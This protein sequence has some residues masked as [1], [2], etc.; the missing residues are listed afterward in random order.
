MALPPSEMTVAGMGE[1]ASTMSAGDA[2]LAARSGR[3]S[4]GALRTA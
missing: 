3:A 4:D 2:V 1:G